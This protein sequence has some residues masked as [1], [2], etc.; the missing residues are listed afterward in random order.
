MNINEMFPSK[1]LKGTD[2]V[3]KHVN[4]TI[5][6][7]SYTD[8]FD[9]GR[10]YVLQ[11]KGAKKLLMLNKTNVGIL[12]WLFPEVTDTGDWIGKEIQ[13][14]AELVS[15]KGKTGPA[16][17]IRG[18]QSVMAAASA[19][20]EPSELATISGLTGPPQPGNSQ[21][22]GPGD[23]AAETAKAGMQQMPTEASDLHEDV[24]SDEVPF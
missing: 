12:Q 4:V 10:K 22:A 18:T 3:D 24:L 16:V 2:L 21:P 5:E 6:G 17:R 8:E 20:L 9:E 14:Y 11:F 7:V 13:L 1:Y 15:F 23:R 19:P